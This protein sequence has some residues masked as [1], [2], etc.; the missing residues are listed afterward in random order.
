[1]GPVPPKLLAAE[2]HDAATVDRITCPIGLPDADGKDPAVIAVG[3]AAALPRPCRRRAL[4]LSK[5]RRDPPGAPRSGDMTLYRAS[6]I[7]V[8]G[9]PFVD[10]P[11]QLLRADADG[12]LL[13]RD[14]VIVARGPF[15]EIWRRAP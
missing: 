10:D 8:P 12:G 5:G 2:G 6:V 11:T 4:S 3:V 14:G 1:M 9:D 15:A 7:D 13:V